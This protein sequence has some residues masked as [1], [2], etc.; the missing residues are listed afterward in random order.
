M[1]RRIAEMHGGRIEV[2][3]QVGRGSTFTIFLP[4]ATPTQTDETAHSHH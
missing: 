3:S 2:R 1:C 4:L